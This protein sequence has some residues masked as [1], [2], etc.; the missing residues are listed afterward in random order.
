MQQSASFCQAISRKTLKQTN[1]NGNWN[2]LD[3]FS[4]LKK[5]TYI[6]QAEYETTLFV[7]MNV[8]LYTERRDFQQLYV[9]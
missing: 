8:E 5:K 4:S 9:V 1:S 6:F 3:I 2:Y 7:K